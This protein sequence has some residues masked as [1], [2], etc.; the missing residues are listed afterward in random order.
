V[1]TRT[2]TG[3][4]LRVKSS[5]EVTL[6]HYI[7]GLLC[8]HGCLCERFNISRGDV[9]QICTPVRCCVTGAVDDI[10]VQYVACFGRVAGC[11]LRKGGGVPGNVRWS[12]FGVIN[13]AKSK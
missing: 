5:C 11:S 2:S 1:R 4:E 12:K 7:A 8:A 3:S 10:L 13:S 9:G 6:L